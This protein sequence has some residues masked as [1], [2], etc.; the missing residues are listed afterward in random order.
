M[1]VPP[2]IDWRMLSTRAL[3]LLPTAKPMIIPIGEES[4]NAMKIIKV[5]MAFHYY[6]FER[7]VVPTVQATGILW[8]KTLIARTVISLSSSKTPIASPSNKLWIIIASPKATRVE[9]LTLEVSS[10]ASV[11]MFSNTPS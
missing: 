7:K 9:I 8:I 4:M 6:P 11:S 5:E 10:D 2:E 1:K 3:P